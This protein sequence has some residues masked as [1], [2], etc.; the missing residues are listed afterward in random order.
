MAT[1]R[2][3][4]VTVLDDEHL[5]LHLGARTSDSVFTRSFSVLLVALAL[6]HHQNQPFLSAEDLRRVKADLCRYIEKEN[7]L[8]GYVVGKGWAHAPAHA[9]DA[10]GA[11]AKCE[12]LGKLCSRFSAS[13]TLRCPKCES[14]T[15]TVRTSA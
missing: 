7:D 1:L 9:A 10:L 13:F 8:R 3:I 4:L 15:S 5:F 11:L 12:T 2:R 14:C 6:H